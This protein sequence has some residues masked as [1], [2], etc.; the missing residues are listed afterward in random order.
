MDQGQPPTTMPPHG[1]AL[2]AVSKPYQI[3]RSSPFFPPARYSPAKTLHHS[4]SGAER[5]ERVGANCSAHPIGSA[6][7][8]GGGKNKKR[9]PE[10]YDRGDVRSPAFVY[11]LLFTLR[12]PKNNNI[13]TGIQSLFIAGGL[14]IV[15]SEESN[16]P[17]TEP[18]SATS[19][20]PHPFL[21]RPLFRAAYF[22]RFPNL[23]GLRPPSPVPIPFTLHPAGPAYS[24]YYPSIATANAEKG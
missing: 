24:A 4:D 20:F 10:L 15:I 5:H 16:T 1:A 11:P 3:P 9:P 14:D 22:H 8:F 12:A 17:P 23:L 21:V 19:F 2:S 6:R 18:L 13:F 7:W